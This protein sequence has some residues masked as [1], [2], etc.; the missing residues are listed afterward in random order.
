M[1]FNVIPHGI[2]LTKMKEECGV[3]AP[4]N[5][6]GT[7]L[8]VTKSG[9]EWAFQ[10]EIYRTD[11]YTGTLIECVFSP[12]L[13]LSYHYNLSNAARP[14]QRRCGPSGSQLP[15]IR[16]RRLQK[17][18]TPVSLLYHTILCG[19]MT[20]IG[21]HSSLPIDISLGV[22]TLTPIPLVNTRCLN[23]GLASLHRS[24][25]HTVDPDM[26]SPSTCDPLESACSSKSTA[27]DADPH[28]V[29]NPYPP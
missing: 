28:D 15:T 26:N 2:L 11:V 6:C 25:T 22:P 24:R 19:P 27:T 10:I 3:E 18:Q 7:L 29:W 4:L 13:L 14:G 1:V 20:F 8:F 17:L 5:H 16:P 23:G 9:P 12:S 21:C